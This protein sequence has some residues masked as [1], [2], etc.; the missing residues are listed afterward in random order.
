MGD[1]SSCKTNLDFRFIWIR[2]PVFNILVG[3]PHGRNFEGKGTEFAP[4]VN[5]SK[6]LLKA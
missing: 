1:V 3:S 5:C 4:N 6:M 2:N